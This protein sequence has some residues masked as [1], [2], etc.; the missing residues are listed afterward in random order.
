MGIFRSPVIFYKALLLLKQHVVLSRRVT[1][2]QKT[3]KWSLILAIAGGVA[4]C[5]MLEERNDQMQAPVTYDQQPVVK[6]AQGAKAV[7]TKTATVSTEPAQK[8]T[9]GPKRAAAPQ[10]PVIQ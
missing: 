5:H 7:V 2:L 1:M 6:P 8:T 9:P 3:I 4:S 10:L